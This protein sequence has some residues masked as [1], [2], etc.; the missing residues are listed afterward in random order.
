MEIKVLLIK[1]C[2][3][4][5]ESVQCKNFYISHQNRGKIPVPT[6]VNGWPQLPSNNKRPFKEFH[7]FCGGGM[8]IIINYFMANLRGK[9][10][11]LLKT[12]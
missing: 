10:K 7:K 4:K 1:L 11:K 9:K 6:E 8:T 5:V 2:L 12:D 3:S